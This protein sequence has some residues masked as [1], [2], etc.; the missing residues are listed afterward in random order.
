MLNLCD[1]YFSGHCHRSKCIKWKFCLSLVAAKFLKIMT[2]CNV[3]KA[4]S[5]AADKNF[6]HL[7]NERTKKRRLLVLTSSVSP[8]TGALSPS[9]IISRGIVRILPVLGSINPSAGPSGSPV[10]TTKPSAA[11]EPTHFRKSSLASRK[12][13]SFEE[14]NILMVRWSVMSNKFPEIPSFVMV[15]ELWQCTSYLLRDEYIVI[16]SAHK[17]QSNK[18]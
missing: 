10:W 7:W 11:E 2:P 3:G 1:S 8:Y 16:F 12:T 13:C 17:T 5:N 6:E 15:S 4:Y 18:T 9:A 14:L